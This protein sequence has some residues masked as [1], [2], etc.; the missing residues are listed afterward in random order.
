M[1]RNNFHDVADY[2]ILYFGTRKKSYY[3]EKKRL[4]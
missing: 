2:Y 1:T 3:K 4:L